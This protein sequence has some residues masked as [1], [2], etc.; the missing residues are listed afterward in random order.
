MP[1]LNDDGAPRPVP[2][3]ERL[4]KAWCGRPRWRQIRLTASVASNCARSV[5]CVVFMLDMT[6]CDGWAGFALEHKT[7]KYIGYRLNPWFG[8]NES[9]A[10]SPR[11]LSSCSH[12]RDRHCRGRSR[13]RLKAWVTMLYLI[14]LNQ[15]HHTANNTHL[16]STV[17]GMLLYAGSLLLW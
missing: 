7:S 6:C 9:C 17:Y 10:C 4:F 8:I 3:S 1:S 16:Q 15:G 2:E 5:L 13:S 12:V 11:K 14:T